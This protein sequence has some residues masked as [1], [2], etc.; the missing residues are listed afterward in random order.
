[1]A[2]GHGPA[3]CIQMH[4]HSMQ[5]AGT[6]CNTF[7]RDH[8]RCVMQ[9]AS[10]CLKIVYLWVCLCRSENHIHTNYAYILLTLARYAPQKAGYVK[11]LSITNLLKA[12]LHIKCLIYW[13]LLS[14][15]SQSI[16][17]IHLSQLELIFDGWMVWISKYFQWKPSS[18][19]SVAARLCNLCRSHTESIKWET[20][21]Y[22]SST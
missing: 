15:E 22:Y 3:F 19:S 11:M 17:S 20:I 4:S 7:Y 6:H 9:Y 14:N 10:G 12:L 13:T 2:I 5:P 18:S 21:I 16:P 8:F 1:M